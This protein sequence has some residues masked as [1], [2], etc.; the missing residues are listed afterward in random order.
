[1]SFSRPALRRRLR[2]LTTGLLGGFIALTA[3]ARD[4]SAKDEWTQPYAGVRHLFRTTGDPQRIHALVVDLCTPGVNVRAT[5]SGERKRTTSSFGKLVGA[6]AAINGDFFSYADYSTSGLSMGKGA[7]W[8]DTADGQSSGNVAFGPGRSILFEPS[9]V[10]KTPPAGVTDIVSGRP[11]LVSGGKPI[12]Q[13][14]CSSHYCQR[15]PRTAV[16]FSQDRRTLYLVVVDGRTN[17][18]KG[19]TMK[20]LGALLDDL[21]A[22]DAMNLDGGGST[23]M[24]L[25]KSGVVND[26][27]D[28]SERVV[29]NHLAVHADGI[30]SGSAP[31][32]IE[33][34]DEELLASAHELDGAATSDI[35]GDGK[36]DACARA[37]ASFRC[38]P[39]TGAGF[40]DYVALEDLGD[41]AGF[42]APSRYSTLRMGD[43]D[44]DGLADVCARS[45]TGLTCWKSTGSGFGPAVKGPP[46]SDDGGWTALSR[47]TTIRL[48]DIDGDGRDD[49]CARDADRFRC[50]PSTGDGFGAPVDGP[51]L[52]DDAGWND[53]K[54]FGT[55][56]MGDLDGDG[57]ADV[58]A[59]AAEGVRCW[60]AQDGGFAASPIEGPAWAD[61]VG[62]N[63]VRYWSTIRLVDLDGDGRLD[64]CARAAKGITCRKSEG[65]GFGPPLDGPT[66][67]DGAG[68]NDQA[69]YLTLKWGDV[70][71]DSKADV[72]GRANKR[73]VCWPGTG[74]GF[75]D[76]LDGPELSDENG[77]FRHIYF[78]TI[79]LADV[80]GDGMDDVCARGA[81]GLF[82]WL[83]DGAG[84]PTKIEGPTWSD[85]K[86]WD[87]L[88][89][90]T[91]IRIAGPRPLPPDEGT[92]GAGGGGDGPSSG[93][94]GSS[95]SRGSGSGAGGGSATDAS[96]A[97][98]SAMEGAGSSG[99]ATSPSGDDADADAG[100]GC[101]CRT[102]PLS[103]PTWAHAA[104]AVAALSAL[105]RRRTRRSDERDAFA[106]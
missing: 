89:Y 53:P 104:I 84:F 61:D 27:S 2:G 69:N 39:S 20:E 77:W 97:G 52:S 46:L 62:W 44:G 54:R 91:T 14:D 34:P 8:P 75:G 92:G 68:W 95:G 100:S 65:N 36:A 103:N 29:A 35:D 9:V 16:G 55:I 38:H 7:V 11:L 105:A 66:I 23:T 79:R 24:W 51:E 30:A 6:E 70:N 81:A 78:R 25:A 5:A 63:E 4:A 45:A 47:H 99:V 106:A 33:S 42:D 96:G 10:L 43:I 37:S 80:N 22:Y 60:L 59:R 48:A 87:L 17:I 82:C 101:A 18:A 12:T 49:V 13:F 90:Y 31:A 88:R 86:G 64:I 76:I 3:S 73:F 57:R 98:G 41:A 74:D 26:P 40:A 71:G 1:M 72:C 19:M 28:G 94:S 102:T 58:C 67:G 21:G 15:H 32:C 83:S 50:W 93:S 56:R 85:A